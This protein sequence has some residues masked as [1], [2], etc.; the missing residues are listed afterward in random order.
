MRLFPFTTDSNVKFVVS[1]FALLSGG[2][3]LLIIG[4]LLKESFPAIESIGLL[5]FFSDPSWNPEIRAADGEFGLLTMIVASVLISGAALT[6]ALPLAIFSALFLEFYAEGLV[7]FCFA[8]LLEILSGIPS[9]L[10]GLWGM[11]VL[12]PML[13]RFQAPGFSLLC[14][15]LVLA[16]MIAPTIAILVTSAVSRAHQSVRVEGESLA[17][18]REVQIYH[19]V[20]PMSRPG[21]GIASILGLTRAVGETMVVVMLCGNI[22]QFPSSIFDPVRPL[23]A[24]I[25]LEMSYA[26][27]DH[28]S[29][30]YASGLLLLLCVISLLGLAQI[31]HSKF[32]LESST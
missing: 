14:A 18:S 12:A 31:F 3:L 26:F 17:L 25:A 16:I 30:L 24:S 8:R 28:R 15:A 19:L 9:V 27:G 5:R 32:K 22:A 4:F 10:L 1:A 13:A 6:L 11:V 29:S 7:A 23:T 20:L 2:L 21:I